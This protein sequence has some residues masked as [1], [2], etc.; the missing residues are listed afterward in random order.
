MR[1]DFSDKSK[2]EL[3]DLVDQVESEKW[4]DV[5]DWIGDRFLGFEEWIGKLNVKNYADDLNTYHKKVIDKNNTSRKDIEN[6]FQEAARLDGVYAGY[7][8]NL[9]E[10][11]HSLRDMIDSLSNLVTPGGIQMTRSAEF[12]LRMAMMNHRFAMGKATPRAIYA[13]DVYGQYGGNQ[14]AP[15]NASQ[16]EKDK[17]YEIFKK[18][19]PDI[20]LSTEQR[21]ALFQRLNSEGCGYVAICNTIFEQYYLRE[22]EFERTFGYPMYDSSGNL[23][24]NL[25]LMDLYSR[26]DNKK[27]IMFWEIDAKYHDYDEKED[28]DWWTYSVLDDSEG[29]GTTNLEREYY[30]EQFLKEHG[31]DANVDINVK[32]TPDN[33]ES[34]VDSGKQ[35]LIAFRYGYMYTEDGRRCEI[36][37]GHSMTVTGVT[38]DGR[39]IVSS[40]GE[41][42]Y[43]DPNEVATIIDKE[44]H[45]HKTSMSFETIEYK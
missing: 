34:Y 16:A 15:Q 4:S 36:N 29:T 32:V 30:A 44:G 41:K 19:N 43:I 37:G 42:Y 38:S 2:Q 28:G 3:H 11:L 13:E 45:E 1:R 40:W 17:M 39:Y 33:Y 21:T 25:L 8:Q 31:I 12:S 23:N 5:T 10:A 24:Y 27:K 18:N 35:V 7:Y 26:M 6:I 9:S 20:D 22:D 14:G